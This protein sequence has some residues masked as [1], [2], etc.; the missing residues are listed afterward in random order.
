MRLRLPYSRQSRNEQHFQPEA[1]NE[2]LRGFWHKF[3]P[4]SQSLTGNAYFEAPPPLLAA[5]PQ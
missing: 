3:L 4:R 2:V 1:G 5:E